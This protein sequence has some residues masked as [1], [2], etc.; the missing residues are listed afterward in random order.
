MTAICPAG[1]PKLN[2]ATLTH[3]QKASRKETPWAGMPSR[4]SAVWVRPWFIGYMYHIERRKQHLYHISEKRM[5]PILG[6]ARRPDH[7]LAAA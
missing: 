1:P 4:G 2:A 5:L 3:T 7:S 6:G